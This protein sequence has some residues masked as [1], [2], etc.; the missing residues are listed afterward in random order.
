MMKAL[1]KLLIIFVVLS[2]LAGSITACDV[3][4]SLLGK[5]VDDTPV[6]PEENPGT[7]GGEETPPI[8]FVDYVSQLKFD[9]NSGRKS[10]KVKVYSYIDGDTTHFETIDGTKIGEGDHIKARYLAINTPESTGIIEPWGKKASNYTQSKLSAATEII[11]E[12]DTANWDLDSTGTRHLLWVWYKPEGSTEFRNLNL[13]ILQEGLAYGSG[14]TS[15]VYG[16]IALKILNQSKALKLHVFDKT[17][18]DPNYYYGGAVELTLKEIKASIY[19]SE[20]DGRYMSEY[21]GML[22]KFEAIVAKQVGSTIYV[23]EYDPT[24]DM[25]FGMQIFT[26]YA[27][28][29]YIFD[30]IGNR[31][32]IVGTLQYWANGNTYQISNLKY[33]TSNPDWEGGCRILDT[34]YSASYRELDLN[35]LKNGIVT[36]ETIKEI[37]DENGELVETLV[38]QEFKYA[39]LVHYS[40]AKLSQLT[41]KS[42]YAHTSDPTSDSYGALTITCED[43]DGNVI[44]IHTDKKLT[45]TV[46]GQKVDI[47]K[48]YFPAGTVITVKG[49]VDL[50]NGEYQL[51]VFSY[52]DITFE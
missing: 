5:E 18:K 50:Y 8:E 2:M 47:G 48:E 10:A 35:K 6:T 28:I 39:E 31:V 11:I 29:D 40:T 41:V 3:V 26:G 15:N 20:E 13:E 9:P 46:D 36:L 4:N 24:N 34:G 51:R 32:A 27:P 49:I 25:Y 37:Q 12:S 1:S 44:K 42:V 38:T 19:W 16:E 33:R 17:T 43:Q 52:N 22:V 23:E 45:T 21:D 30:T 14:V 7:Q